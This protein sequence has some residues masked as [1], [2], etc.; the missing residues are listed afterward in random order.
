MVKHQTTL[1]KNLHVDKLITTEIH[2]TKQ[3]WIYWDADLELGSDLSPLE[4]PTCLDKLPKDMKEV[5]HCRI[6]KKRL[7]KMTFIIL[8]LKISWLV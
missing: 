4:G 5:A 2:D 7:L 1:V 6:F 3:T 8:V